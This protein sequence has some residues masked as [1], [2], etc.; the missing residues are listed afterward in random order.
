MASGKI[1]TNKF[2]TQQIS[3]ISITVPANSSAWTTVQAPDNAICVSGYY[4]DSLSLTVRSITFNG[5]AAEVNIRNWTGNQITSTYS[6][7]FLIQL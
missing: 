5:T 3:N 7:E 4:L 2:K 1:K 6:V